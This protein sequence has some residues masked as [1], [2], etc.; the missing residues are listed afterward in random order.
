VS[1]REFDLPKVQ[2]DFGLQLRMTQSLFPHVA[3]VPISGGLA[4]FWQQVMPLGLGLITEKARS[5][6]ITAP[7]L[8]EVW[9]HSNRQIVMLSGVDWTVDTA[10][11]LNGVADF[12][13]CRSSL[14][15]YVTAP[16]LIAVEAKR[17][18]I[19]DG[20]GQCAA[21]MVAAQRFNQRAGT[22]VD[23][24]YGCVT[25]GVNWRFLRLAGTQLDIDVDEYQIN[26]PD[27]ILGVLLFCCGVKE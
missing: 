19:P 3:P 1:F 12:L 23:P 15:L 20:L 8:S 14:M 11:G 25:T 17:D 13:L 24:V 21:E 10:V 5:E 4:A 27:R 6:L 2:H 22:P 16:V 18:S 7:L 9:S 26:Q